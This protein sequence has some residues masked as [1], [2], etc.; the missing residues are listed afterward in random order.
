[1]AD[2]HGSGA[3]DLSLF[4]TRQPGLVALPKSKKAQKALKKKTRVQK[5]INAVAGAVVFGVVL[6]VVALMVAGRVRL[7]ELSEK[8]S[9][10]NEQ[11]SI[12]QSEQIRL[13]TELSTKI[14]ME[15]VE[16]YIEEQGMQKVEPYQIIYFT[17]DGG[18]RIEVPAEQN[19]NI[20]ESIA[21]WAAGLFG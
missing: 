18:E 6:T 2:L 16:R 17:V 11:L 4:E 19:S 21:A 14:S 10:L 1:M 5:L 7:T 9:E 12:L 3:Y 8:Q 20:F 15:N 13:S